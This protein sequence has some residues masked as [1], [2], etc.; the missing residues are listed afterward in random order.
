MHDTFEMPCYTYR[1][2]L[3]PGSSLLSHIEL[4]TAATS[5]RRIC[6]PLGFMRKSTLG[7]KKRNTTISTKESFF[8]GR[9]SKWINMTWLNILLNYAWIMHIIIWPMLKP[10]S[11][12]WL[13][14]LPAGAGIAAKAVPQAAGSWASGFVGENLPTFFASN[15][16]KLALIASKSAFG[17]ELGKTCP[18]LHSQRF[19]TLKQSAW[20]HLFNLHVSGCESETCLV[21]SHI[22]FCS[23]IEMHWRQPNDLLARLLKF[24]ACGPKT[25]CKARMKEWLCVSLREGVSES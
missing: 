7:K 24:L 8:A 17:G 1:C 5:A 18:R 4:P 21:I 16:L 22:R 13:M 19:A 11:A 15:F 12:L 10:A 20:T 14:T 6:L 9:S 25:S 23:T 2:Q 3:F